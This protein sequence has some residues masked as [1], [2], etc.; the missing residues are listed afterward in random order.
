M[1][2]RSSRVGAVAFALLLVM[3]MSGAINGASVAAA[4]AK[5]AWIVV[6]NPQSEHALPPR[7]RGNSTGGKN[8]FVHIF[9]SP[10]WYGIIL[11]GM[12]PGAGEAGN[13]LVSALGK[14]PKMCVTHDIQYYADEV[15]LQVL[16]YTRSGVP[17]DSGFVLNWLTASGTGG[18][19]AYA[20]DFSP[21]SNCGTPQD[22]YASLGGSISSCPL[23]GER[24]RVL[25]P[26]LGS[27]KGTAQVSA[28]SVL[29]GSGPD[30]SSAG[31]CGLAAMGP[32]GG[33]GGDQWLDAQ[34][35]E[36]DGEGEIYRTFHVWF[37]QG[38]GM[39]GIVRKNV[40]YL[41]ADKPKAS[42]Y[43]PEAAHGY[44]S[45]GKAGRVER[46]G[47]GRYQVTLP[48]MPRGGSA[49]VTP[50]GTAV[51][52]CVIS[53]IRSGTLPQRVGVRCFN[54]AGDPAD[55]RFMLAYA[56]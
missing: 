30:D 40:A 45:A 17:A 22:R 26:N 54:A 14:K 1:G 13:V 7:D 25:V 51:R 46:S 39:K 48:G 36:P 34:C 33:I 16:C 18:R 2:I 6:R 29:A 24:A 10:G 27:Y 37:M 43:V 38:L 21:T 28:R 52:H 20:T 53:G 4:S 47:T 15:Q 23:A 50:F 3:A 44:S 5:W 31:Y 49:Q 19:L 56:R 8:G 32:G 12:Q 35:F 42:S 41:L 9:D 55:A 11:P